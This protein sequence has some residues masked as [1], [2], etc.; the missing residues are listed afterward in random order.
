[1]DFLG[2]VNAVLRKVKENPVAT[3][4]STDMANDIADWVNFRYQQLL[5]RYE[6][7][8]L[9]A[10][11]TFATVDGT[12]G[13]SLIAGIKRLLRIRNSDDEPLVEKS[14]DY[15]V[16]YFL[17]DTGENKPTIW[18]KLPNLD[19]SAKIQVYMG[20]IP[21]DAYTMTYAYNS[22]LGNMVADTDTPGL[23]SGSGNRVWDVMWD[24][25]LVAGALIDAY[26]YK[27]DRRMNDQELRWDRLAKSMYSHHTRSSEDFWA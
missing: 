8:F 22:V 17:K 21:D 19:S 9:Y 14:H 16:K 10:E 23:V 4:R 5:S 11:S 2:M 27:N 24:E 1:M 3:V 20:P 15:F 7:P 12:R 18:A 6:W 13:Y 26:E 25:V